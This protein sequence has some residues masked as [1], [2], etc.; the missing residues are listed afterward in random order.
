MT[1]YFTGGLVKDHL[2]TKSELQ[3]ISKLNDITE[4][5]GGLV[6][7]LNQNINENLSLIQNPTMNL[8]L[9]FQAIAKKDDPIQ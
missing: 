3:Q 7:T 4:L 6:A 1:F 2:L 5:H 9:T 8:M